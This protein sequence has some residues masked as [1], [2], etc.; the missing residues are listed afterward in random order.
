V[1][2]VVHASG[3]G[4][5]LLPN[6]EWKPV[7]ANQPI[8][9]IILIL[10]ISVGVPYFLLTTTSPLLQSWLKHL[11]P[12]HSPY[13]LYAI[14]N[15]GSL[16]GLLIYPFI[17]EPFLGLNAQS[18]V[19]S[20]LYLFFAILTI[21]LGIKVFSTRQVENQLALFEKGPNPPNTS[22][23]EPLSRFDKLFWVALSSCA[24]IL[25]LSITNQL[26][27][28]IAVI[29][30]LWI[31]PL[32][33]YLISFM[34]TFSGEKFYPRSLSI[35]LF[36]IST[37]S[38][39]YRLNMLAS[40]SIFNQILLFNSFLLFATLVCHGELYRLRPD[41]HNLTSF[42]LYISLGGVMG[43]IFVNLIAPIIFRGYW[44]LHAG[45][46]F[47][48]LLIV[49]LQFFN[50]P[51][52]LDNRW[53]GEALTL[54]LIFLGLSAYLFFRQV[55]LSMKDVISIQRNFYGVT[56][57][58]STKIDSPPE[59]A[60]K[61]KHGTTTHGSQFV[62]AAKRQIPTTYYGTKSGVGLTLT[63]YRDLN[64]E[65]DTQHKLKIGI[66][67]LGIGTLATY[68]EPGD[69]F[70]FY[71]INPSM[72][73]LA[74]GDGDYFTYLADSPSDVTIVPGDA[75]ISLEKELMNDEYQEFDIFIVDAFS[76]DS[77]PVHLLTVEAFE[78]YLQ[79]LKPEGVMAIHISNRY[80]NLS[81]LL[82]A[83]ADHLRL[84]HAFIKTDQDDNIGG[85]AA[86]WILL[87]RNPAFFQMPEIKS[88]MH[89]QLGEASEIRVWTDDFSNLVPLIKKDVFENIQ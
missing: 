19:W 87:S 22:N 51:S 8:V 57:V 20:L 54:L 39:G 88:N 18:W 48:W 67:G 75:R 53:G 41:P 11:Q 16:A 9:K 86:S 32:S 82:S 40:T 69:I 70:R 52:I 55:N 25:L 62:S 36:A 74:L 38:V 79:Q 65:S 31:L 15:F 85:F 44:E 2:L 66:I 12:S 68:G 17:I 5:P 64:T 60:F 84:K 58:Q 77:I 43:G 26:T 45:I 33:I 7:N 21:I 6:S 29:P 76:S 23:P 72:I 59:Y 28:E 34:L 14:S 3:W 50:R 61:L 13:R 89:G 47:C 73:D 49:I 4:S 83:L 27:Q 1:I 56:R 30:F 24:S 46:L 10:L 81:P 37:L 80:L 78:I 71:E 42:Y 63:N 35:G